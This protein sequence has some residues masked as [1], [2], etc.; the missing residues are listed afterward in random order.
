MPRLASAVFG[1]RFGWRPCGSARGP[2][3]R[4]I[5]SP[6]FSSPS[7]DGPPGVPLRA[8]RPFAVIRRAV[9]LVGGGGACGLFCGARRRTREEQRTPVRPSRPP[10]CRADFGRRAGRARSSRLRR[11]RG[12]GCLAMVVGPAPT[13]DAFERSGPAV[14][15]AAS[16]AARA[17]RSRVGP[18]LCS[19]RSRSVETGP[20]SGPSQRRQPGWR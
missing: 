17:D 9:R 19:A 1:A 7:S 14:A 5:R 20:R 15:R 13:L 6:A 16:R 4:Q 2:C 8:G 10:R 12:C 11:K 3:A 18:P